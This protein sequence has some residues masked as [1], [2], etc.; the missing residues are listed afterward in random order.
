M[1]SEQH[2]PELP[3]LVSVAAEALRGT[4]GGHFLHRWESVIW[5]V[6]IGGGICVLAAQAGRRTQKIPG[7]VQAA[8]E[9]LV[10]M[11]DDFI[12]GLL[13]PRGRTY[14]PFLGTLFLYILVMNLIGLVPFLKSPTSNWS[15]TAGL[16]VCVFL[17]VQYTAVKE[18]GVLGYIDHLAG[19]PRGALAFTLIM[20]VFMFFLHLMTEFFRPLT[21]SLRLRSNIWG[22]DLMLALFTSWGFKGLPLLFVNTFLVVMSSVIQALVFFLLSAIY[23][24]L[25]L[26]HED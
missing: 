17:Y 18:L 9:Y 4:G 14:T 25:V 10:E 24:A 6:A 20:P 2:L 5:A 15:L 16:A 23:F 3:N 11:L 8:A 13:G 19:R 12:C 1:A 21:L 22:E 26:E 7:R